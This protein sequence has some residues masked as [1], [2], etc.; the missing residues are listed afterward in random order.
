MSESLR[1]V[2]IT[3]KKLHARNAAQYV[4]VPFESKVTKIT[5]IL[6]QLIL[7]TKTPTRCEGVGG[8]TLV[9]R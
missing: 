8:K 5:Y 4:I 9:A 6:Q 1:L 2:Y 3:K 7:K